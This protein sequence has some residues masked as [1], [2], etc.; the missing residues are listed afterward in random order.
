MCFSLKTG[1][2]SAASRTSHSPS[3][4]SPPHLLFPTPPLPT[5]QPG[6]LSLDLPLAAAGGHGA[7]PVGSSAPAS[8]GAPLEMSGCL[9]SAVGRLVG[10]PPTAR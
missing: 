7:A 5:P 2:Y 4:P 1:Y 3:L 8:P 9:S 6:L 10:K